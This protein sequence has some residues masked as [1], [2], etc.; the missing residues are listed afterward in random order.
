MIE[1]LAQKD[2]HFSLTAFWFSATMTLSMV[3]VAAVTLKYLAHPSETYVAGLP[4]IAAV[5]SLPNAILAGA[6]TWGKKIDRQA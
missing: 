6:Y 4:S 5:L 2:G 3:M 1:K